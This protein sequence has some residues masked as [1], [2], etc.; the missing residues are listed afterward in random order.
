[1]AVLNEEGVDVEMRGLAKGEKQFETMDRFRLPWPS[2]GST[3][4]P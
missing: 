2:P 3:P 4:G 1:M